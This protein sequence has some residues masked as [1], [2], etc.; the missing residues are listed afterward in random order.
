MLNVSCSVCHCLILIQIPT[1]TIAT[2]VR[3][4]ADVLN[5]LPPNFPARHLVRRLMKDRE[6]LAMLPIEV[7][8]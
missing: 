8:P 2:A 7:R 6:F 1:S 5:E 4:H 3:N